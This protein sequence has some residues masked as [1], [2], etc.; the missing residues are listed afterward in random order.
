MQRNARLARRTPLGRGKALARVPWRRSRK[1]ADPERARVRNVVFVRDGGCLLNQRPAYGGSCFGQPTVH[2]LRK[3]SQGGAY[4]ADNLV[5]LCA[6]H[7]DWVEVHP[8][9][10]HAIGL[11]IRAGETA[12]DA[13]ARRRL[14]G[15]AS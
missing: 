10:A 5:T 15:L 6:H 11:V 9:V 4:T 2:H 7:N 1:Q 8:T 3:A 13:R 14:V 12:S